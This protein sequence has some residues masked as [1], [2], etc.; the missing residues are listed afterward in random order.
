MGQQL[1]HLRE[2]GDQVLRDG[3]H[4]DLTRPGG[5]GEGEP[6]VGKEVNIKD[7]GFLV[8][9]VSISNQ[10]DPPTSPS[11]FPDLYQEG[12]GLFE[13]SRAESEAASLQVEN[14][15]APLRL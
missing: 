8:P 12:S 11:C 14:Y 13:Y 4:C 2:E 1:H 3:L 15:R 7:V 10:V 5:G 6:G 9:G